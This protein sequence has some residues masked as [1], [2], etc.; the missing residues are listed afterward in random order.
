[1]FRSLRIQNF[2]VFSNLEIDPLSRIN[3]LTGQNN[4]GK[5]SVLEALF[6]LSAAGNPQF[7]LNQNV[8]RM[9]EGVAPGMVPE[10]HWKAM[11]NGFDTSR[12]VEISADHDPLGSLVLNLALGQ[13]D[14]ITIPAENTVR[15]SL[16]ETHDATGLKFSYRNGLQSP[17]ISQIRA[18]GD[19]F[20]VEQT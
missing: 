14:N 3:L 2:R 18:T 20:H 6:L 19:G 9:A 1:M 12:E 15:M 13:L 11:F 8:I 17:I 5:T 4:T 16:P 10:T 7:A